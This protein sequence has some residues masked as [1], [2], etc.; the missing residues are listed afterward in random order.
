MKKLSIITRTAIVAQCSASDKQPGKPWCIYKENA[1]GTG[2]AEP[3]PKG[4][5]KHYSTK[6][7]A[8]NGL[9]NMKI[10]GEED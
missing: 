8:N 10:H 7:D 1:A 9:R 5:P 2:R 6:E 4:W 3:Q